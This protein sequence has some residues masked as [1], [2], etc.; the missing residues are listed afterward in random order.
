[1]QPVRSTFKKHDECTKSFR[2]PTALVGEGSEIIMR[3]ALEKQTEN[4]QIA[5]LRRQAEQGDAE[6]RYRLGGL[7]QK[8]QRSSAHQ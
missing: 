8:R 6:A 4:F 5:D 1:M 2:E 7:D 3:M